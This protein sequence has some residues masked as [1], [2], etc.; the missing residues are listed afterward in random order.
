MNDE[1]YRELVENLEQ[2]TLSAKVCLDTGDIAAAAVYVDL[3]ESGSREL[4]RFMDS[5]FVGE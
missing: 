3:M 4:E 2:Y 5:H 1:R